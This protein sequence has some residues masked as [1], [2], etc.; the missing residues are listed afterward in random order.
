[1]SKLKE[2][3]NLTEIDKDELFENL[4]GVI[5]IIHIFGGAFLLGV[6]LMMITGMGY[7]P[8]YL[9]ILS[10]LG[11]VVM[12]LPMLCVF[13]FKSGPLCV[14]LGPAFYLSRTQVGNIIYE[15]TARDY[16]S[17]F[18][19]NGLWTI[20]KLAIFFLL[21]VIITP[22]IVIAALLSHKRLR[23]KALAYAEEN[24]MDKS[25]VPTYATKTAKLVI[26]I[27]C[28]IIA[29]VMVVGLVTGIASIGAAKEERAELEKGFETIIAS[30]PEEYYAEKSCK[31]SDCCAAKFKMEDG[32]VVYYG[33]F[34][35]GE[36]GQ[37]HGNQY[38][39]IDGKLYVSS[40]G[41]WFVND[42]AEL[43][44]YVIAERHLEGIVG[45]D[46]KFQSTG[47]AANDEHGE[48]IMYYFPSGNYINAYKNGKLLG[49]SVFW[50]EEKDL[51]E[52]KNNVEYVLANA[53]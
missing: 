40:M 15:R 14:D 33:V 18:A 1:M 9:E 23:K 35:A 37:A 31:H 38:Y 7:L 41:Y 46:P 13:I 25:E 52:L 4:E 20:L 16:E 30:L 44:D 21:S 8:V 19:A 12:G 32:S 51:T 17:E 6:V 36:K 39:I 27:S 42:N 50:L 22:I 49:Y 5:K 28:I 11:Y 45:D 3:Q 10:M 47:T 34:C 29:V 26:A 2:K 43:L 48:Y 53:D 24:G